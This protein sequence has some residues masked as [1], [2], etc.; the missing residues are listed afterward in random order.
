MVVFKTT[1]MHSTNFLN[2][3]WCFLNTHLINNAHELFL[4]TMILVKGISFHMVK[5]ACSVSH[6]VGRFVC[7][8]LGVHC[9]RCATLV[10]TYNALTSKVADVAN[11]L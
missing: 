6:L 7:C 8:Q 4:N 3:S 5:M 1:S 9:Y 11:N 2:S 10:R